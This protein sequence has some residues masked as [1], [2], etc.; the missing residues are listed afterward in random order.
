MNRTHQKTQHS[1]NGIL[2]ENYINC[3]NTQGYSN[4]STQYYLRCVKHYIQ[5][6]CSLKKS[7]LH[8]SIKSVNYFLERHF[9][10]CKCPPPAC[11]DTKTNRAALFKLL[12]MLDIPSCDVDVK[13]NNSIEKTIQ[14]YNLYL[15]DLGGLSESTR[16]YR[17]RYA[18]EFLKKIFGKRPLNYN[19]LTPKKI[20][21]Y[22]DSSVNNYKKSSIG[23]LTCS[24]RNFLKFLQFKGCCSASLTNSV[25][26]V[27]NWK[28]SSIPK[29]LEENEIKK[30]LSTFDTSSSVGKRDFA[31]ARC[32]VDIGLRCSEVANLKLEDISWR[33][34][35]IEIKKSKIHRAD[36]LPMPTILLKALID[37]L[38]NARPKTLER[39]IF[40]HHRAPFGKKVSSETVRGI[41][42]RAYKKAGFSIKLTG[43]CVL[44]PKSNADF[45]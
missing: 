27:A 33:K 31:I 45:A 1:N 2:Y 5:W 25:P 35:I 22:I 7:L 12:E 16:Y 39:Y 44:R 32:L 24:V 8:I 40:V 28:L 18:R 26:H 17:R 29:C 6:L 38:K 15:K 37:Y 14:E 21:H 36:I 34:N 30:F 10:K 19:N 11:H 23:V 20:V 3:L 9:A 41:I 43:T 4:N 13:E 42:R